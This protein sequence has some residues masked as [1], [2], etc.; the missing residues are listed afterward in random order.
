MALNFVNV[1][2]SGWHQCNMLFFGDLTAC[3]SFSFLWL[4]KNKPLSRS[5]FALQLY[6]HDAGRLDQQLSGTWN[7]LKYIIENEGFASFYHGVQ[8]AIFRNTP[9][10]VISWIA[11]APMA[12]LIDLNKQRDPVWMSLLKDF[13]S[14]VLHSERFT[15]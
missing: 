12:A 5:C 15:P 3:F 13:I 4:T 2:L 6:L 1:V 14:G 10:T 7:A 8:W 9:S 11:K